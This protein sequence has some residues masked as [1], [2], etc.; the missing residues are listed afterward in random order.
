MRHLSSYGERHRR[1]VVVYEPLD[2]QQ[3]ID[4]L[5]IAE[6]QNVAV[7]P[8]G[9]CLS[10]DGQGFSD[11]VAISTRRLRAARVDAKHR[12]LTAGAGLTMGDALSA[13]TAH[14]LALPVMPSASGISLGGSISSDAYSRMTPGWGRESRHLRSIRLVTPR[15][16]RLDC[17]REKNATLFRA[18]VGGFGLVGFITQVDHHLEEVGVRPALQSST[19][20]FDGV[21][22]LEHLFPEVRPAGLAAGAWPGAGC[23]VMQADRRRYTMITRHRVIDT[24]RRRPTLIHSAGLRRV[25]LDLLVGELPTLATK[26]WKLNWVPGRGA[27]FI[28]DLA[29]ATFF[30]DGNVRAAA[31][32]RRVGRDN[33]AFQQSYI[34]PIEARSAHEVARVEDFVREALDRLRDTG[35][36]ASMFDVGFLPRSESFAL[37]ANQERDAFLVSLAFMVRRETQADTV[38]RVFRALT[39][40]CRRSH[41]GNIHLTKQAVCTDEELREMYSDAIPRLAHVRAEHDP[42]GLIDTLLGRRLGLMDHRDAA[43]PWATKRSHE[44]VT[45][46]GPC[47]L[48]ARSWPA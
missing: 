31:F 37:S 17:S 4:L 5:G 40:T 1:D 25:A 44:L 34:L 22:G 36:T 20:A 9:S 12:R 10:F 15:G 29:P 8:L 23:I 24:P 42:N 7:A 18:A 21:D 14:G 3:L 43:N 19:H 38:T 26:L 27:S 45:G 35:L 2:E 41:S 33:R 16:E 48:N 47:A 13:T 39:R 30:M 6:R 32:A 28:D 11:R 46:R